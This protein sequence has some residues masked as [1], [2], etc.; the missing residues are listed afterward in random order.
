MFFLVN[1]FPFLLH[2]IINI[3]NDKGRVP[4]VEELDLYC[5]FI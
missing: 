5:E 2:V 4:T 3:N 1:F